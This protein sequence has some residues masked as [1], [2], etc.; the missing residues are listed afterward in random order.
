MRAKVIVSCSEATVDAFSRGARDAPDSMRLLF[1]LP[2]L[3]AS[4]TTTLRT[5]HLSSTVGR[6]EWLPN[7]TVVEWDAKETALIIVDM[8]NKH[9]CASASTRVEGLALPM[10][11]YVTAMRNLG[12]TI[13]WAPSDV[14]A[15]YRG[16]AARNNTLALPKRPLPTTKP[17]PIPPFPLSTSTDGG[18]DLTCKSGQPQTRQI[19]TLQIA[20]TDFL[21]TSD[22]KPDP[23]TAEGTQEF[24]NIAGARNL[25]N[26]LYA[27][28]HE[29]MCIMG[30]PW[31]IEKVRSLG[32]P[33][34]RV[35]VVRELVDVMYTPKDPP[36]VSH[37][38]G[39][40]L[41]TA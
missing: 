24:W 4:L 17:L 20:P 35:A 25:K 33:Q 19:A 29:N 16:T 11:Q 41:H 37:A 28:V 26:L 27:G 30:R 31:A 22:V 40:A 5:Q 8:W 9:W 6:Q 15:F 12:V 1:F 23:P 39:L 7:N 2:L 13:I 3:S 18:C 36:Y 10:Q 32:W 34:E 21:V 14:T 38:E